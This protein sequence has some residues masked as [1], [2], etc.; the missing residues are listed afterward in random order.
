MWISSGNTWGIFHGIFSDAFQRTVILCI[1]GKNRNDENAYG[2]NGSKFGNV[3][4]KYEHKKN[5][6]NYVGIDFPESSC[7]IC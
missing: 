5:S 4:E 1:P 2:T 7:F 6:Q 3:K